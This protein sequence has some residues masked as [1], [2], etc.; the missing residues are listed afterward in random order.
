MIMDP[1]VFTPEVLKRTTYDDI[2]KFCRNDYPEEEYLRTSVWRDRQARGLNLKRMLSGLQRKSRKTPPAKKRASFRLSLHFQRWRAFAGI[3]G[4][5]FLS[6]TQ[7][8][9]LHAIH[10][11][12]VCL[13][14][15]GKVQGSSVRVNARGGH[16]VLTGSFSY[17][18]MSPR[19][20]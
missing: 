3:S 20:L 13:R 1:S 7:L 18:F 2:R 12:K 19:R 8:R 11:G 9:E 6:L 14:L 10:S 16:S 17:P 15:C 4:H 5:A